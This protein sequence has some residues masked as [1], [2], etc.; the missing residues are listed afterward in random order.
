[1]YMYISYMCMIQR[2]YRKIKLNPYLT[3]YTQVDS[4]WIKGLNVK[5]KTTQL[6]N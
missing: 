5:H 3:L 4:R 1:M 2:M 6:K